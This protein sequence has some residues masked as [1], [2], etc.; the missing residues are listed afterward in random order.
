MEQPPFILCASPRQGNSLQAARV[1]ATGLAAATGLAG[2]SELAQAVE[3]AQ[4]PDY[5]VLPCIDCGACSNPEAV[6]P[7]EEDGSDENGGRVGPWSVCPQSRLD[8]SAELFRQLTRARLVAISS[9]I[10]FYHLPAILK[11]LLDR[12]QIYWQMREQGKAPAIIPARKAHIILLAARKKGDKLFSGSL[13]TLKYALAPFGL[14][15][16]EPLLL[17]GLDQPGDL[18]L[19]PELLRATR[20][21]GEKAAAALAARQLADAGNG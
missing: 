13:V 17:H 20:A 7:P 5:R 11:A 10:Y 1:F 9:P 4:L 18:S 3:P 12:C 2:L 19:R 6:F 14:E 16:A 15:L 8:R 21:Y